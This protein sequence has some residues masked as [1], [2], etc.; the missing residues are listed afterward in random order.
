MRNGNPRARADREGDVT[1]KQTQRRLM[2]E[3]AKRFV[4]SIERATNGADTWGSVAQAR[5]ELE[6]AV[7]QLRAFEGP[8]R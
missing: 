5:Y 6:C 7:R 2:I 4:D 3:H 8:T 1:R